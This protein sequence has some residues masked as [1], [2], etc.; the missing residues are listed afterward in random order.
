MRCLGLDLG[1]RTLGIAV[2]DR[3]GIISSKLKTVR[4]HQNDEL[5]RELNNI[6]KDYNIEVF[7]LGFPKNMNNTIGPRAE[8]TL[9]F[10][11]LLEETFK[12]PVELIDERLSTVEAENVLISADVSRKKRK[13]VIDGLAATIILDTYLRRVKNG[14]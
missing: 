4:Y 11:T 3:G 6:M 12:L 5:L 9:K 7:V 2:S 1:T 8:A 13:D 14:K 10:K